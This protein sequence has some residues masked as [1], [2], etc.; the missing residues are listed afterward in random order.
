MTVASDLAGEDLPAL[1]R[2]G[3][4]RLQR[5]V[6]VLGG[7]DVAGHERGDEREQP[8]RAEEEQH[9]RDRE[10]GLADVA[11]ER[12][13]RFGPPVCS[14]S[15]TTK[16]IGTSDRGA[17]PEVGALLG[18]QLAQLPAVDGPQ[19]G[20]SGGRRARRR[21]PGAR[22]LRG[23]RRRRRP[24]SGGRTGPRAWPLRG[25]SARIADAGLDERDR[26]L[27]GRRPRRPRSASPS[28]SRRDVADAALAARRRST[29]AVVVGRAQP[30]ARRPAVRLSSSS[31][32]S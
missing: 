8:D 31:A 6:V 24:R 2:A 16:M 10:P 26:Q 30:V 21:G 27:G 15:A 28:P 9:E 19:A 14:A 3:E 18:A 5:P 29:R 20:P 4:D 1:D 22:R 13:R 32:P 11:P 25:A 17:E 23:R 12:R 7:D